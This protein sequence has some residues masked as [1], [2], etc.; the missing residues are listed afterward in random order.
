MSNSTPANQKWPAIAISTAVLL[1]LIYIGGIFV[2]PGAIKSS[3]QGK[4][5]GL[6]LGLNSIYTSIYPAT[7][8]DKSIAGPVGECVAYAAGTTSQDKKA[9]QD[10]YV[11]YKSYAETYPKGLFSAEAHEQTAMVLTAWSKELLA[12]K[13]YEQAIGNLDLV[14]KSYSDTATEAADLM[15]EVY[16]AWGADQRGSS[17]FAGSETTFKAFEA[18]AQNAKQTESAKTAQRELAQTYLAWGLAL[19]SQKQFE[20]AKAKLDLAIS[21]DASSQ[22]KA[23]QGKLYTQWGDDL[24]EKKEFVEAIERYKIVITLSE[25]KEQPAAKDAVANGYLKWAASLSK[26]E[27]FLGA[28]KQVEEAGKNAAT[29]AGKKSVESAKTDTYT[30]FSKSSGPQARKAMRD[31][32]KTTCE[33]KKKPDLPIFG[34]DKDKLQA[35]IYGVDDRLP[36]NVAAKTPSAM[37]YVACVEE[38]TQTVQSRR[39]TWRKFEFIAPFPRLKGRSYEVQWISEKYIW[40]ITLRDIASGTVIAET[41]LEG[42]APPPLPKPPATNLNDTLVG[43]EF[44]HFQGTKP[45]VADL[46]K[47]LLT[48]MK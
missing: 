47:W 14:L 31:A 12:Q 2:L 4:N 35:A 30:A 1:L 48:V 40:N 27:D 34:L 15:P 45:D 46:A 36:D 26:S 29:D 13:K 32:T 38:G 28:L 6:T 16:T 39:F 20:D 21:T 43:G 24:I 23:A 10:S 9:W 3:Y 25:S 22:A 41:S 42:G 37:H 7:M 17:D 8:V 11:A 19:Q 33:D 5:C 44:Q 18:W